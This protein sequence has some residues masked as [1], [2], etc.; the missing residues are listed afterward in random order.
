MSMWETPFGEGGLFEFGIILIGKLHPPF[1][2]TD[3][4]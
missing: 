2:A 1:L 4:P 3:R